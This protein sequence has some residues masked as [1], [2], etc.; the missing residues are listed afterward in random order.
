MSDLE[1]V[2]ATSPPLWPPA[3][4]IYGPPGAGKTSLIVAARARDIPAVDLET[5]GHDY[6]S[7][8]DALAG[9]ALTAPP[10]IIGA[11]DATPEDFPAGT[12]FVLLAPAPAELERRVRG[13]G[14]R[15]D[16]KWVDHALQVRLEHLAMADAG[17]FDQ[18]IEVDGS[19]DAV[20]DLILRAVARPARPGR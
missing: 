11:A 8:R 13:R 18:V 20:L 5:R 16:F 17:V 19:P 3:I 10:T 9:L 7:R 2:Q 14:D 12:W 15:R 4:A 1:S 6:A